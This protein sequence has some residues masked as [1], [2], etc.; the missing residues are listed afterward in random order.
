M[1]SHIYTTIL[2]GMPVCSVCGCSRARAEFASTQLKKPALSRKCRACAGSTSPLDAGSSAVERS[3]ANKSAT[4]KLQSG[5]VRTPSCSYLQ[6]GKQL[7]GATRLVCKACKAAEYC[8]WRCQTAHWKML[9]GHKKWCVP[10]A[11]RRRS[12]L[13]STAACPACPRVP[14]ADKSAPAMRADGSEP[15]LSPAPSVP[16]PKTRFNP[17]GYLSN[18]FQRADPAEG[19]ICCA[20][21]CKKLKMKSCSQCREVFYCSKTCQARD[22]H[23]G[24]HRAVCQEKV[25]CNE[26]ARARCMAETAAMPDD[27]ACWICFDN[28]DDEPLRNPGCS[29]RSGFVHLSCLAR[30]AID[31]GVFSVQ[32]PD[33][34]VDACAKALMRWHDCP[35]CKQTYTGDF[36]VDMLELQFARARCLE[37]VVF[38]VH[39]LGRAYLAEGTRVLRG[40]DI[41]SYV[42]QAEKW[43]TK[44]VLDY[45]C[46]NMPTFLS[47]TVDDLETGNLT[48][49]KETLADV[50][51][52]LK[53]VKEHQAMMELESAT[54]LDQTGNH[55]EAFDS[56]LV[57]VPRFTTHLGKEHHST[58]LATYNLAVC[59]NRQGE[60][61]AALPL[62]RGLVAL[63]GVNLS[64]SLPVSVQQQHPE[65]PFMLATRSVLSS[66]LAGSAN[67]HFE[68]H[69]FDE[70]LAE[71]K[72]SVFTSVAVIRD[73]SRV[74]GPNHKDTKT[75][76]QYQEQIIAHHRRML[77]RIVELGDSRDHE[78]LLLEETHL[79]DFLAVYIGPV[80]E[81]TEVVTTCLND[82]QE[83]C[84]NLSRDTLKAIIAA[85][86][87]SS[88]DCVERLDLLKRARKAGRCMAATDESEI[89]KRVKSHLLISGSSAPRAPS[90][91]ES[92][93]PPRLDDAWFDDD[94]PMSPPTKAQ[95]LAC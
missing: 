37:D 12:S 60:P 45:H 17:C 62:L 63:M 6:C 64:D 52:S 59:F 79:G 70:A 54:A 69:R 33:L 31:D 78:E 73:Q 36:H 25:A 88:A 77:Y 80:D 53:D 11:E 30:F 7:T 89:E 32:D 91:P 44:Q 95:L 87:L 94:E 74:L 83:V 23:E 13:L 16:I 48:K 47:N 34:D 9:G 24:E 3:K 57:L 29:C 21:G 1:P 82:Y 20:D 18:L 86:G 40:Q 66:V 56:Y 19:I 10:A 65:N 4:K 15:A 39:P 92:P 35:T 2:I 75:S 76:V 26:A 85:G 71:L 5:A 81:F 61:L 28:S 58:M 8:S 67:K 72:E 84:G 38:T 27:A 14:R 90:L 42:L 49:A 41:V 51:S 43:R 68:A 22:W 46:A 50:A 93:V 55:V